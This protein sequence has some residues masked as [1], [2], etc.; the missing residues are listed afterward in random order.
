[1]NILLL[2]LA[3]LFSVTNLHAALNAPDED[4]ISVALLNSGVS[5]ADRR[6]KA[7]GA[8]GDD[9]LKDK[10]KFFLRY[11]FPS[12]KNYTFSFAIIG[13]SPPRFAV[14]R[15]LDAEKDS[16]LYKTVTLPSGRTLHHFCID[17][18]SSGTHFATVIVDGNTNDEV[19]FFFS[20]IPTHAEAA[21]E[22]QPFDPYT[23]GLAFA[24]QMESSVFQNK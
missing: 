19:C 11:G 8:P 16:D 14:T 10:S 22:P 5:D 21:A 23:T 18:G 6:F 4:R 15:L 12:T 7:D 13:S 20:R 3:V 1:M 24:L 17:A 9:T 2:L